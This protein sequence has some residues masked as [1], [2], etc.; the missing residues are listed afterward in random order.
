MW[1]IFSDKSHWKSIPH[2]PWVKYKVGRKGEM[3]KRRD[4]RKGGNDR[5]D[6]YDRNDKKGEMAEV[7]EKEKWQSWQ[8]WQKWRVC[9][10]WQVWQSLSVA[11]AA[12][13]RCKNLGT[14]CFAKTAMQAIQR[15]IFQ[16]RM[17]LGRLK[18]TDLRTCA[19]CKQL[20]ARHLQK[21]QVPK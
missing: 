10:K 9:Q 1:L 5:I 3:T 6:R 20:T 18:N 2:A 15:Y 16:N 19:N 13:P 4:G 14:G 12:R 17:F 11:K 7:T 8:A 21:H